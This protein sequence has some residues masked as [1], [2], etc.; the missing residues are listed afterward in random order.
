LIII[1]LAIG[2]VV[3]LIYLT[4]SI[5]LTPFQT[6]SFENTL[7]FKGGISKIFSNFTILVIILIMALAF[8]IVVVISST[9]ILN[10]KKDI[11]V[12]KAL[13]SLPRKIYNFYLTEVYI[14]FF[15]GFIL[16]FILGLISYGIVGV[17][18]L[19]NGISIFFHFD[20]FLTPILFFSCLGGIFVVPGY[21]IRKIGSQKIVKTLS[22]DIPH[23]FDASKPLT[24]IPKWLSLIGFNFKTSVINTLRRKGEFKR[25]LVVFSI[26]SL[27]IFTLAL[28]VIV[29]ST[30]SKE[31]IRKSQGDNI[32]AIGHQDVIEKYSLM[33]SMFS[34]PD[35]TINTSDLNLLESEYLFNFS[36]IED[37]SNLSEVETIDQRLFNFFGTEELDGY[38]YYED[39]GYRIVGQRRT[40]T[41]P[42]VGVNIT[43]IIQDF[44]IEGTYFTSSDSYVNM[45]IGDGLAYNFFDYAFDQSLRITETG[46]NFHI[47]GVVIDT[48]FSGYTGYIDLQIFQEDLNLTNQEINLVL[49]KINPN[50]FNQLSGEFET[51]ILG[52][53]GANFTFM[54]LD[55]Y[56]YQNLRFV[57]NL[58]L[59]PFFLI[60]I[61]AIVSVLSLYN[62]Q[63]GSIMDKAK[64]FLIM[65]AIGSKNKLITRILFLEALYVIIPS[66]SLSLGIG[67]ILNSIVLFERV[68]LP[69]LSVP[70]IIIGIQFMF[71]LL[72]NYLSL[73]PIIKKVKAFKI[74]DFNLY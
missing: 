13:G 11:A 66:V 31:W 5:G 14:M 32:L 50:S 25:Y 22:Q 53:L 27:I 29:L 58:T 68:S 10:K 72:F 70:F 60:I 57:S 51:I 69:D 67:M 41:F 12:M 63:K 56:F 39:G 64:D 48:F 37:L 52:N 46:H 1:T 38:R 20:L 44:E 35:L 2:L 62:Y 28:G 73:F 17:I 15:I 33:Y 59:Y 34:D 4:S 54:Q 24:F 61:M 8:V 55:P 42:I 74:K 36:D 45:F 21:I 43:E 49:V 26:I 9:L 18:L 19:F 30:S 47:S 71:L 7:F 23:N 6:Y 65:R 40:G 16:G 3:F